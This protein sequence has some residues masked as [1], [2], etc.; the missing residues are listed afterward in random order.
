MS[1]WIYISDDSDET[2]A[3]NIS[4]NN[5]RVFDRAI[6]GGITSLYGLTGWDS[7]LI[8]EKAISVTPVWEIGDRNYIARRALRELLAMA[9]KHHG[10]IWSGS[11]EKE[12]S[13]IRYSGISAALNI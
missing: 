5:R 10:G 11:L 9:E 12:D 6:T 7:I 4:Y 1:W 2:P 13:F 3:I 8:L